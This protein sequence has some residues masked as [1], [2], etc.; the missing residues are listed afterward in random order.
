MECL[1]F[2]GVFHRLEAAT[3]NFRVT[4]C[5]RG[6]SGTKQPRIAKVLRIPFAVEGPQSGPM[7]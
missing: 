4:G 3:H 6:V 2:R 1:F 5:D 7:L